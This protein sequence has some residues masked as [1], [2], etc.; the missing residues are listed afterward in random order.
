[1]SENM[2]FCLGDGKWERIGEGYQKNNR[3]FNK[4]VSTEELN[5]VRDLLGDVKITLTKWVNE[6]DLSDDEKTPTTKQIGGLLKRFTYEDA[7]KNWWNEASKQQKD[8]ILTLP[9]FD[10]EIFKS[11][12]GIDVTAEDDAFTQAR[13]LL[14]EHGYKIVKQ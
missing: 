11:I 13:K 10:A 12:T 8:L 6:K 5:R 3:I 14:E 9:Q 4:R 2:I 7:W 1:M